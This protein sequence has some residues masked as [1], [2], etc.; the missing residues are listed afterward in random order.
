MKPKKATAMR[1]SG[2]DPRESPLC[3]HLY[4]R[5]SK[6]TWSLFHYFNYSYSDHWL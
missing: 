5:A 4:T 2:E 6:V 1:M 3:L